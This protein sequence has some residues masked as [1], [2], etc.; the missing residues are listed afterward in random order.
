[1]TFGEI[2]ANLAIS[3][4]CAIIIVATIDIVKHLIKK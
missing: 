2:I 4:V 1:M 3:G